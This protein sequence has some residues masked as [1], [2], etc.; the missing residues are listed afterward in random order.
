MAEIRQLVGQ[1]HHFEERLAQFLSTVDTEQSC[2][3]PATNEWSIR[4][5]VGHLIDIDELYGERINSML[6]SDNPTFAAFQPDAVVT[7]KQYHSQD[8][9]T[10]LATYRE[11]RQLTVDGLSTLEAD[12]LVRT[13]QHAK[14]GALTVLQLIEILANHDDVHWQQ[15]QANMAAYTAQTA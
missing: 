3:K 12:E 2:Y 8:L 13:A 14:F 11:R 7:A 6:E 9:A 1:L 10:L 4:E 15:M 5:I